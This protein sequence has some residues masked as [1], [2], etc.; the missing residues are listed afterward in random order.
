MTGDVARVLNE[1][2]LATQPA[3][4]LRLAEQARAQLTEWPASHFGYRATGGAGD[5]GVPRRDHRRPAGAA[6]AREVAVTFVANVEPPPPEGCCRRRRR[7]EV[8]AQALS[9]AE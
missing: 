6:G 4:R 8:I 9:V 2:A 5:C 3:H 7:T 1:I